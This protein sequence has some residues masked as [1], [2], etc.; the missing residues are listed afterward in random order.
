M[1]AERAEHFTELEGYKL[2]DMQFN[3][4]RIEGGLVRGYDLINPATNER[5]YVTS[6]GSEEAEERVRSVLGHHS[7]L[8]ATERTSDYAVYDLS[9]GARLLVKTLE[10]GPYSHAYMQRLATRAFAFME[11]LDS[12]DDRAFGLDSNSIA[13]T[14]NGDAEEDDV[15]LTVIPPLLRVAQEGDT[16]RTM[17]PREVEVLR[18]YHTS[19][20][21]GKLATA[22]LI[23]RAKSEQITDKSFHNFDLTTLLKYFRADQKEGEK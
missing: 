5:V 22:Q 11:A 14:H 12:I 9:K 7:I 8:A 21:L 18:G 17:N 23:Q 10:Q 13:I 6:A 20:I 1:A 4:G 19:H 3:I 15:H 2:T 16:Q